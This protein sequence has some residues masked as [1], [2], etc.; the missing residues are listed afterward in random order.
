MSAPG[1]ELELSELDKKLNCGAR[2]SIAGVMLDAA[3][4]IEVIEGHL[5]VPV[6]S[7]EEELGC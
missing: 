5:P 1:S 3:M 7:V 4:R 2:T 6:P